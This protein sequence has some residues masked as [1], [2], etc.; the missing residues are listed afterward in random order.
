M[1]AGRAG[2]DEAGYEPEGGRVIQPR[3]RVGQ[4]VRRAGEQEQGAPEVCRE[5]RAP[6]QTYQRTSGVS[7]SFFPLKSIKK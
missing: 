4:S 1:I 6:R 7:A 3:D 5:D 2:E